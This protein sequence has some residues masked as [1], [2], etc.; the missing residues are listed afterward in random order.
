M[1][2]LIAATK[3]DKRSLIEKLADE[4]YENVFAPAMECYFTLDIRKYYKTPGMGP[5]AL[6]NEAVEKNTNHE[7]NYNT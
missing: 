4:Y 1:R 6:Q 7:R 3:L 2:R 5:D